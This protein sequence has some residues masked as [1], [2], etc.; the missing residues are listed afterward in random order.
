MSAIEACSQNEFL[1][2][3]RNAPIARNTLSDTRETGTAAPSH[4]KMPEAGMTASP[5]TTTDE[6]RAALWTGIIGAAKHLGKREP[7]QIARRPLVVQLKQGATATPVY[8]IGAGLFEFHLAQLISSEQ[9]VFAVEIAWPSTWHDAAVKN[10][11]SACPTLE[12]MVA[13][14]AAAIRGH[15]GSSP[16][17]LIGYSFHGSMAFEAAHQLQALGTKVETVML[18]DAPADY[19]AW[20]RV[21]W[22]S[23]QT[24]WNSALRGRARQSTWSKLA[25]SWPVVEWSLFEIGK[26]VKQGF[27]RTAMRDPGKLT[28]KL[29][30][31]GRPLH[32]QLIER[33]YANSLRNYRLRRLNAH[34]VVFRADRAEDCPSPTVDH[35]LGWSELFNDGLAVVQMTGGHKTMMQ[36]SPHDL[37]LAR[38]MSNVLDQSYAKLTQ[39]ESVS[40]AQV[41]S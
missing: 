26:I 14:Y 8:F 5:R 39:P 33:L 21:A 15:A 34:G 16:C 25:S 20:H 30:S 29:D 1:A 32:W 35:S 24:I 2:A 12:E 7:L 22:Q 18:L 23:L 41:T 17:V 13:P 37:R 28:T 31:L 4:R 10:D 36:Q 11:I 38:E 40:D 27:L 6:A 19:P 3:K 9:S